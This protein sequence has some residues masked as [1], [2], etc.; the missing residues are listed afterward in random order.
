MKELTVSE[1]EL[2]NG[3]TEYSEGSGWVVATALYAAAVVA[4][5]GGA[6]AITG[7]LLAF[8]QASAAL[9]QL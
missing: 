9:E 2:V 8:A 5:G 7:A 6:I 3:G 4:T 1:T